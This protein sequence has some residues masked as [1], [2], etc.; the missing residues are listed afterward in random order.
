MH[1]AVRDFFAVISKSTEKQE[2]YKKLTA[3]WFG[4]SRSQGKIVELACIMGFHFTE[5]ELKFVR[6]T[7]TIQE[8]KESMGSIAK[9]PREGKTGRFSWC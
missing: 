1:Q 5:E 3:A 9:E 2:M 4:F 8:I 6:L 7:N